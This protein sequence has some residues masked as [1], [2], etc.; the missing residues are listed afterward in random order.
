MLFFKLHWISLSLSL[1]SLSLPAELGIH[2]EN[3]TSELS[4]NGDLKEACLSPQAVRACPLSEPVLE[5]LSIPL[6]AARL[7][8]DW[9]IV[10][11]ELAVKCVASVEQ[12]LL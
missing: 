2:R 11:E 6:P 1:L 5:M 8:L 7:L 10:Q 12:L 9:W 4:C 3:D